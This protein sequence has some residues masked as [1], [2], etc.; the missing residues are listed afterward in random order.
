MTG[1]RNSLFESGESLATSHVYSQCSAAIAP[2]VPDRLTGEPWDEQSNTRPAAE[3]ARLETGGI[4]LCGS[5]GALAGSSC[6]SWN[7]TASA[8]IAE[9]S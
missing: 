1:C 7:S 4:G 5:W 8:V 6:D 2:S 3:V 9:V